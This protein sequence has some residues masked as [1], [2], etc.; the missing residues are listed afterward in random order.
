[1]NTNTNTNKSTTTSTDTDTETGTGS[2]SIPVSGNTEW[3]DCSRGVVTRGIDLVEKGQLTRL[4]YESYGDPATNPGDR[5]TTGPAWRLQLTLRAIEYV[6]YTNGG[7]TIIF[8]DN[9]GKR[10]YLTQFD[11]VREYP[12]PDVKEY[13]KHIEYHQKMDSQRTV[14]AV[15]DEN[16]DGLSTIGVKV[17]LAIPEN[18]NMSPQFA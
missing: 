14:L 6:P 10:Y 7:E 4:Y 8:Q 9:E 5:D 16:G 13:T 3:S 11:R 18:K 15:K 1:M 17:A 12:E 2:V